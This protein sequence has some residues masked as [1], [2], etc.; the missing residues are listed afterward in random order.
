[1]L[2]TMSAVLNGDLS[3]TVPQGLPGYKYLEPAWGTESNLQRTK[4]ES[5][6]DFGMLSLA[7]DDDS[8]RFP[9]N[10]PMYPAMFSTPEQ[11]PTRGSDFEGGLFSGNLARTSRREDEFPWKGQRDDKRKRFLEIGVY[12]LRDL[13]TPEVAEAIEVLERIKTSCQKNSDACKEL[14]ETEKEGVWRLLAETVD[15]RIKSLSKCM[16]GGSDRAIGGELVSNL[17]SYYESIGDVQ[18]LATMFCVLSGGVRSTIQPSSTRLLPPDNDAKY[19]AYIKKYAEL[20]YAWD[21]LSVRAE[22]RKHLRHFPRQPKT[23]LTGE[24]PSHAMR[25]FGNNEMSAEETANAN[26]G[27]DEES[28]GVSIVIQCP[29]CDVEMDLNKQGNYCQTCQDFPFRCSLCDNAVRGQFTYCSY[30]KHGG[31]LDHMTDWFVSYS[32][33]PT[34]CGCKCKLANVTTTILE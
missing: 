8:T 9:R 29:G 2:T 1:M 30:C 19:D 33:C 5:N 16:E 17:F 7:S 28:P 6:F 21:L 13:P 22:V 26:G 11:Y 15:G 25:H 31:H 4:S 32:K 20:L 14:K 12:K 23:E 24:S 3:F 27:D 10:M 18:M 34:G